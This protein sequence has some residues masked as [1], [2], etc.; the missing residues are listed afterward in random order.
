MDNGWNPWHGCN[1]ISPGCQH[2]YVYRMDKM[3]GRDPTVVHRTGSFYYP[4]AKD[5]HGNYK[6]KPSDNYV[7][8]CFTSDFFLPEADNWRREAW[9]MIH[10][11]S[12]L[13]F[14]FVTK[15]IERLAICM[16]SDWGDGYDNVTI[17][18]TVENQEY[19]D[20]RLPYL[21]SLP[22]KHREVCYEPMLE[23]IDISRYLSTGKIERVIAGGESGSDARICDYKWAES[24]SRQCRKANVAFW[25]KQTGARFVDEYG[26]LHAVARRNQFSYADTLGLS[27]E[28]SDNI[29]RLV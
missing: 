1:K 25:F 18:A 27:F 9:G 15:R 13:N 17:V 7:L 6:L 21:L 11:R 29:P 24:M 22:I 5:R 3:Y 23:E 16:P 4:I 8:T 26:K 20:K 2:C 10:T 19:A 28:I 14:M 12:D